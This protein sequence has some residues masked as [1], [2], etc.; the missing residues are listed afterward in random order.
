M[1][2]RSANTTTEVRKE[3]FEV[4][5]APTANGTAS[6]SLYLDDG[7]SLVQAMTSDIHFTYSANGVFSMTGSFN[8]DPGVVI[9]SI[10]VLGVDNSMRRST[11]SASFDAG[12]KSLTHKVELSLKKGAAVNLLDM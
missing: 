11:S 10:T 6:G 9:E 12:A 1:R 4:I 3:N 2:V 7:D 8:Y 5:I